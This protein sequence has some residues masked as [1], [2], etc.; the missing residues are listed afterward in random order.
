MKNIRRFYLKFF[1][2]MVVKFFNIF[3]HVCFRN[4]FVSFLEHPIC[5]PSNVS[6]FCLFL[7][8]EIKNPPNQD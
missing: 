2:L 4:V 6:S 8:Y 7:S 5:V 1:L 3:E